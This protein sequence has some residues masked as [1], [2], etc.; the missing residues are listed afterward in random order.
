[1]FNILAPAPP[2]LF[3]AD[4][5]PDAP[6]AAYLFVAG[7]Y[8]D[9]D[10]EVTPEDLGF[11]CKNF[12]ANGSSVPINT[13]HMTTPLDP[14]GEVVALHCAGDKLYGSLVF[15]A[16]IRQHI[17]ERNAGK[18][19]CGFERLEDGTLNLVH[20]SIVA[21][22]RVPGAGFL[23]AV[24]VAEKVSKFSAAGKLTPATA[25]IAARILSAPSVITFGDGS[26]GSV[27]DD[28]AAFL[29]AMP[30]VQPRGAAVGSQFSAPGS[31]DGLTDIQREM[32]KT[33]GVDP[34]AV[35]ATL[36]GMK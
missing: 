3:S 7:K 27:A 20:L 34:A 22:P 28:F 2:L 18:L 23:S 21:Q 4:A 13:E 29:E 15:S 11:I 5:D 14:L 16:G 33:H 19:S 25:P 6:I 32:C 30:V 26:S 10:I 35:A 24:A 1:M 9:K 12:S 36:K 31:G 8:A 17:T